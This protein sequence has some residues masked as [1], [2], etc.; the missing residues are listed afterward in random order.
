MISQNETQEKLLNKL[1]SLYS[2]LQKRSEE[3]LFNEEYLHSFNI[4]I[5]Q[6]KNDIA[7]SQDAARNLSIGIIGA[8]KAGKSSFLNAYVFDGEAILP[9]AATPMTAALTKLTYSTESKAI[10]HFYPK[11]EW[12]RI[13]R[14]V[15]GYCD[16][17]D[18]E[19]NKYTKDIQ[20][21]QAAAAMSG[22]YTPA[23][24]ILS[25]EDFEIKKFQKKCNEYDKA[26]REITLM[27][28]NGDQSILDELGNE[29]ILTGAS[30]ED[31]IKTLNDY[32]GA[33]GKYTPI[34]NYVELQLDNEKLKGLEIIDTPGLNDP[35]VSRSRAT[36]K[37]LG[38][39]DVAVML[40]TCSQFMEAESIKLMANVLPS[41][42]VRNILVVGSKLD[43]GVLQENSKTFKEAYNR[44]VTGYGKRFRDNIAS[45]KKCSANGAVID[46][47]Q[48]HDPL[49]F[50][51]T[52]FVI[53]KCLKE[54]KELSKED[55]LI[56]DRLQKYFKD[57]DTKMLE[58]FSGMGKLK[59][60]FDDIRHEKQ[61]LI[62]GKNSTFLNDALRNF[63]DL[64]GKIQVDVLSRKRTLE[65]FEDDSPEKL[66]KRYIDIQNAIDS[67]RNKLRMLFNTAANNAKK[68]SKEISA[69]IGLASNSFVDI[70]T[71]TATRTD[72]K[73]I[74]AGFLG[75]RKDVVTT[76][77][78]THSADTST[79]KNNINGYVNKCNIIIN[80]DFSSLINADDLKR[81]VK[82]VIIDAFRNSRGE[83]DE[84]EIIFA[85]DELISKIQIPECPQV[86]KHK[87]ID[88][89]NSHFP[90]GAAHNEDIHE[91]HSLQSDLLS[92]IHDYFITNLESNIDLI[93]NTMTKQAASFA[94]KISD[95]LGTRS[96]KLKTQIEEKE[97][98]IES[99]K[100]FDL[101][102]RKEKEFLVAAMQ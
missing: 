12:D 11:E 101:E 73:T 20:E 43:S 26:A 55:A 16:K 80:E 95:F 46:L 69:R 90:G 37:F 58:G 62:E 91:L 38:N 30:A 75:L 23:I 78:T 10:I 83:C 97:K 1:H 31:I 34:V 33:K 72:H 49:Y 15:Q 54:N 8:V 27:L 60:A 29:K 81:K 63:L 40:S 42:G 13:E 93:S 102:L 61:K 32:V 6:L 28:A 59:R 67:S 85:L 70:K 2:A 89:I 9:K 82:E 99:Y 92:E 65:Q 79:V 86:D 94:D 71:D 48:E 52:C 84:Q 44:S 41:V 68:K 19:Y 76:T 39:C 14:A 96:E 5:E 18:R 74:D 57:F 87:Y 56:L 25:K 51:S 50:S 77:T 66:E 3:G 64:L 53:D 24:E 22:G 36:K 4:R 47:F 21:A 35:I 45:A 100:V 17:L 88:D 7:R 98:Y